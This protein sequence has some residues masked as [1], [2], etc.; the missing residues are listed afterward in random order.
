MDCSLYLTF[1]IFHKTIPKLKTTNQP[2]TCAMS[3]C[4]AELPV[5]P[6]YLSPLQPMPL[7]PSAPYPLLPSS[8]HPHPDLIQ[9]SL[10][11]ETFPIILLKA[12]SL[13]VYTLPIY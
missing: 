8:S 13:Q 11:I 9:V 10:W 2:S 5:F 3:S 6:P 7:Y 1:E 12:A 4:V